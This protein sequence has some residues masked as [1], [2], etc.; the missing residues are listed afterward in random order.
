VTPER[1]REI[2]MLFHEARKRTPA[3]RDAFLARACA[4]DPTLRREVESLLAQPPAGVIDVP[5]GALV[6]ELI[7]PPVPR[8]APGSSVGPY[9][10]T[11]LVDVGGMG[12]VYCARDTALGRDVAIKILPRHFTADPERLARFEREARVLATLS[13]PNIAAIYGVEERGDV[14]ALVLELVE[15]ETLAERIARGGRGAR[16]GESFE[17]AMT[18][19]EAITIARQIAEA[20][21]IAHE[22][23]IVHRD[24]KPANIMIT[25][26]GVVKILDFGLAKQAIDPAA[27]DS[28][29][30]GLHV[31]R[32]GVVV[33]TVAYMSPEQAR[34]QTVDKRTDIWAF[35]C[36]LYEMLTGRAAFPRQTFSDTVAAILDTEP[37]WTALPATVP[38]TIRRLLERALEKDPKRRLRDMGDARAELDEAQRGRDQD[39]P[40]VSGTARTS[41]RFAVFGAVALVALGVATAIWMR[42]L[43]PPVLRETRLEIS[44]PPTT[45][46]SSLAISPDGLTVVFVAQSEGQPVLWV[47][48]LNG[49]TARP[50]AGTIGAIYPFWSPDN[51]S[52]GFFADGKLKRIEIKGG[53]AQTLADALDP[54]GG[55]WGHDGFIVF[56]P[57]QLS[58][59][60][61]ISSD[62]GEPAAVTQ[63]AQ[64]H[65]GHLFPQF[66]PDGTH[67]LCF[68]SGA[69]NIQGAY[70]G[71]LDETAPRKL[72]DLSGPAVYGPTGH[73]LFVREHALFAQSIDPTR[74]ELTGSAVRVADHVA[75]D[76]GFNSAAVSVSNTGDI[77]YRGAATGGGRQLTWFNRSGKTLAQVGN[78]DGARKAGVLSVSPDGHQVALARTTDGNVDLWLLNLGRS[79]VMSRLTSD[80]ANDQ[81]A[82]WSR[83]GLRLTFG[84]N[85]NGPLHIFEKS[86]DRSTDE[87]L[88]VT[89]QNTVPADWSPDGHVLLY[90]TADP[91]THLDI[92]ALPIG[93]D[94]KP[95]P[96]IQ[97]LYEDLN[98]QFSPDGTWIA[99]Q[100]GES[101]RHEVYIRPFRRPGAPVP[102]STDG[103]TQPRWR[104]DGRELFYLG[105]DRR[106]MAVSIAFSSNGRSVEAGIP[107]RLFQTKIGGPGISQREYEV[108]PDGQ[109]FL[110][111]APIDEV[112][113]PIIVIQNWRP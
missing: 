105:L 64:G 14:R 32:E 59:L 111:D 67:V 15:G 7:T 19:H 9:R 62:G 16:S 102:I 27:A 93:R 33:G 29:I 100:S 21:D 12:E 66:L 58:P 4:D 112:L 22:K 74:L 86:V 51:Q 50:L 2:E 17:R 46:Q 81:Y 43:T 36:V 47:R 88:L 80:P 68:V 71:R 72:L 30:I 106:L 79:G 41:W 34:G 35:G 89:P 5:V 87:P 99:Y 48:P 38:R 69:A 104:R 57:H 13:H 108:S 73:L 83:D 92:W 101:N 55:A 25:A 65:L 45:E 8:L 23:G 77:L 10:I 28:P 75:V 103:G 70:I 53:A 6:A 94:E 95:F 109:R 85:R 42:R 40:I 37:A 107:M 39:E 63:L 3:Q 54:W 84:S 20:L 11:R 31:T 90:L 52:I 113:A 18:P 44:T 49:V 82:L 78:P 91:K 76:G 61:R 110:M 96:V 60:L 26:D 98:P 56:T 24:L 97:S 1:L